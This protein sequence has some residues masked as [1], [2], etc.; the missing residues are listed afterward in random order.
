MG[1]MWCQG[2]YVMPW[3]TCDAKTFIHSLSAAYA[4]VV[5]W[6]KK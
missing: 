2:E 5:H 3:E 6:K 1:K 4:E